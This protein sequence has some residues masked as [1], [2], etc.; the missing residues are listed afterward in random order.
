MVSIMTDITLDGALDLEKELY[1]KGYEE[2]VSTAA[3]EQFLEGKIYGLQTGFQRFLIVGYI[4]GLLQDWQ[5]QNLTKQIQSHLDQLSKI[6][7]Q[8]Q[9]NNSDLSVATYEKAVNAARNK[10]RVIASLTKTTEKISSLDKLVDEVGGTLAVAS[11]S[12]E[13]W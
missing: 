3:N 6:L 9:T 1:L 11:N 13:M 4:E 7:D 2:G 8:I 12:D 5:L 10:V